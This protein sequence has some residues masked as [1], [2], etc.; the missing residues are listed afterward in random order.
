MNKSEEA[1]KA[2]NKAIAL[3]R[4][5]YDKAIA[6]AWEVY[7]KT[8]EEKEENERTNTSVSNP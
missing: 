3:A 8:R 2:Y 7:N 5:A 1:E 6:L 4:E